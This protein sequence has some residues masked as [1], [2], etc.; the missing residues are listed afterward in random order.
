METVGAEKKIEEERITGVPVMDRRVHEIMPVQEFRGLCAVCALSESCT[1]PR[2][3][4]KPV[5]ECEEF[6]GADMDPAE[7]FIR[8]RQ[9]ELKKEA[10]QSDQRSSNLKGLCK[11]C[12]SSATCTFPRSEGGVWH[13]EEFI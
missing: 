6:E 2:S 3:Q 13:C 8:A 12:A 9:S 10:M 1:F 4:E 7:K 11:T 5:R